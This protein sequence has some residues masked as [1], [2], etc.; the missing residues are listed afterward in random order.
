MQYVKIVPA[1]N[2]CYSVLIR[3]DANSQWVQVESCRTHDAAVEVVELFDY[4]ED[5]EKRAEHVEEY[6]GVDWGEDAPGDD[7]PAT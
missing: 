3:E 4:N 6:A 7:A 5:A 2:G 1:K